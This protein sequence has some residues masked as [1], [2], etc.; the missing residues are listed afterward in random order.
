MIRDAI[1]N[2]KYYIVTPLSVKDCTKENVGQ[3][4]VLYTTDTET[5]QP[6]RSPSV[7][8]FAQST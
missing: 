2:S 6:T 1:H 5:K 8:P 4:L 7:R 3:S